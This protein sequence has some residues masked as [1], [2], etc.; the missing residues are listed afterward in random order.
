[1][2]HHP[3]T[4]T[5]PEGVALAS[6]YALTS[7]AYGNAARDLAQ[8][9]AD[10]IEPLLPAGKMAVQNAAPRSPLTARSLLEALVTDLAALPPPGDRHAEYVMAVRSALAAGRTGLLLLDEEARHAAG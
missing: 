10:Q 3:K 2:D 6:F 7:F 8:A 4:I 1:M 9:C 5:M